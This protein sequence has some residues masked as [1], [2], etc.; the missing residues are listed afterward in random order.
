M[1]AQI[2]RSPKRSVA[3]RARVVFALLVHHAHMRP[4]SARL[5]ERSGALRAR[6]VSAL[7]GRPGVRHGTGLPP[8]AAARPASGAAAR[9]AP[10]TGLPPRS[11]ARCGGAVAHPRDGE[12]RGARLACEA[13]G[14]DGA[15]G[16]ADGPTACVRPAA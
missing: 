2:A 15:R 8:R 10:G 5:P 3:L 6:V 14:G 16:N 9:V 11:A 4:Q 13:I 7:L 12:L 1:P